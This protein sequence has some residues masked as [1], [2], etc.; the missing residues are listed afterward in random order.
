G[1]NLDSTFDIEKGVGTIVIAKPLDA[2]LRSSYNMTVEVTDGTNVASTQVLIRVLDNNDNGPEFTQS[3]Y[4]ATISEDVLPETEI[5][6]IK[7]TDKDENH[8]LSYIVHSSIDPMSMKK[9]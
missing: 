8:K 6:Q 3:S 1:G 4:E 7:A 9:F 5:L 2:E